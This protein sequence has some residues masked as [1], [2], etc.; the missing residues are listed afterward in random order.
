MCYL[1]QS[2]GTVDTEQCPERGATACSMVHFL[3]RF[4][5][6]VSTEMSLSTPEF[7]EN[8]HQES[9]VGEFGENL[10]SLTNLKSF[11]DL[12]EFGTADVC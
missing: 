10:E 12:R 8:I 11:A 5:D 9:F 2:Y 7:Q 4:T 6:K 1:H 3:A